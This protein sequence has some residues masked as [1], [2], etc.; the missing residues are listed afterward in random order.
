MPAQTA[1]CP[2][3]Y[4]YILADK[5]V[6]CYD[7]ALP[8][9]PKNPS[10]TNI[11]AIGTGGLALLPK[12][13]SRKPIPTF[14]A[15]N[16]GTFWWWNGSSWKDTKDATGTPFGVNI[17]GCGSRIYNLEG[18]TGKIFVYDGKGPA[19]YLS[20]ATEFKG[21]G[22]YDLVCDE[23]C[24]FYLLRTQVPNQALLCY[25]PSGK[26]IQSYNLKGMPNVKG[27]AGFAMV[28]NKVYAQVATGPGIYVGTITGNSV[29]FVFL[30][31]F[32]SNSN[33]F[34]SCPIDSQRIIRTLAERDSVEHQK[35]ITASIIDSAA[36]IAPSAPKLARKNGVKSAELKIGEWMELKNI[37]FKTGEA[38]LL[39]NSFEELD[40]LAL[41]L[42]R[43]KRCKLEIF[44]FTDNSGNE[45]TNKQLSLARAAA[46]LAYLVA[47]HVPA[48]RLNAQGAGSS[49]PIANNTTEQ[50]RMANRR[51]EIK[52][53]ELTD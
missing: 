50:G 15:T 44:G 35:K 45:A 18:R 2:C 21:G 7:P 1:A 8:A 14:Y 53:L 33:D 26:L 23:E 32:K 19:K 40:T 3:P 24:N 46:V 43:E 12:L 42:N 34:A 11:P 47:A 31:T 37:S 10:K 4:V 48:D 13:N 17:A 39:P 29:S 6:R 41:I 16:R 38:V 51:V 36:H 28:G 49:H 25:D 22:P 9:G 52:V 5:E 20:T 30:N 27:G